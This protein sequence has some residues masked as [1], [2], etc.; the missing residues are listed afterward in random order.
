MGQFLW[1][2]FDH[3]HRSSSSTLLLHTCRVVVVVSSSSF[4]MRY[5]HIL[6][7]ITSCAS[8]ETRNDFTRICTKIDNNVSLSCCPRPTNIHSRLCKKPYLNERR[9][10]H[11]VCRAPDSIFY[12]LGNEL[13]IRL[14][15][16]CIDDFHDNR[17]LLSRFFASCSGKSK[18]LE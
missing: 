4:M 13:F 7:L 10:C 8:I 16:K 17:A 9:P 1:D 12:N 18:Y 6:F 14:L 11:E 5:I 2:F 15:D 3:L